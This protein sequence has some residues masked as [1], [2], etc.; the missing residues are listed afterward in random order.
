MSTAA[1]DAEEGME[2]VEKVRLTA[3]EVVGVAGSDSDSDAQPV[4][5]RSVSPE[6]SAGEPMSPAD[7]S[8]AEGAH[9]PMTPDS[10]DAEGA[11][12]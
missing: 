1:A 4:T 8:D 2:E 9:R 11:H 6:P 10:S 5:P 7:S 12:L 3:E